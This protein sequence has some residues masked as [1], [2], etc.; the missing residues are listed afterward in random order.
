MGRVDEMYIPFQGKF[1][2][3]YRAVDKHGK[4]ADFLLRPDRG[5]AAAGILS[6]SSIDEFADVTAQDA[7]FERH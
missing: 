3:F 5:I 2:C 7:N 1:S 6:Q 4:T